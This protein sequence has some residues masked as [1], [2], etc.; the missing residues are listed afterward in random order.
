MS[1][2]TRLSIKEAIELADIIEANGGDASSLRNAI[3]EITKKSIG[4]QTIAVNGESDEEHIEA[5]R[6]Q[7]TIEHGEEL[8]CMVCHAKVLSLVSGTCENCF[9][10][11]ALTTKR[12]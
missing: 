12:R 8:E 11:W 2:V 4:L 1:A 7:S 6:K 9:R 3:S 5:L 10:E